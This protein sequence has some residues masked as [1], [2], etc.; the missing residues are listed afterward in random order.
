[1]H[2]LHCTRYCLCV[3]QSPR[4]YSWSTIFNCT[5]YN[6]HGGH[7]AK[8]YC[9]FYIQPV[10]QFP[11]VFHWTCHEH[12]RTCSFHQKAEMKIP[13]SKILYCGSHIQTE[14]LVL[15]WSMSPVGYITSPEPGDKLQ[16]RYKSIMR[17]DQWVTK[18]VSKLVDRG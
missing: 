9:N 16:M 3:S 13:R 15:I 18:W 7:L 1:M 2:R 4:S 14:E 6:S 10:P 5:I 17:T 8:F 11:T 12:I